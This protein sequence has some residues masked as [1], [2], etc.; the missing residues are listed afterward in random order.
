MRYGALKDNANDQTYLRQTDRLGEDFPL[1]SKGG[2][3]AQHYF[4][5]D[6]EYVFKLRLQRAWDSVIRGLNVPTQFE[7][8]V[9]GKRVGTIHA[10]R[11][12]NP[13]QDLPIRRRRGAAVRVP[14]KA[15]LHRVMATM[16]KTDDAEPEGPGPDRLPLFSRHPTTPTSPIAI[17][18][19]L[20]GGPYDAQSAGRFAQPPASFR[21]PS[22]QRR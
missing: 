17:A 10:G 5:V 14:V 22:R 11:R 3:A 7:V 1:G 9:D 2:V 12:E 15:G 8:R 16:L 20:I 18:S 6:G 21:L 19:L 13:I 4:P